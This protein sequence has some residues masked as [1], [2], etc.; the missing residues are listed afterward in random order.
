MITA[1]PSSGGVW[2]NDPLVL[3]H[4]TLALHVPSIETGVDLRRARDRLDFGRGFYVTTSEE[5]ARTWTADVTGDAGGGA[6]AV[7]RFEITREVLTG[8]RCLWFVR[9]TPDADA[10][11]RFVQYCRTGGF[12]HRAETSGGWYDVVAGPVSLNWR[13]RRTLANSDQVS[14]HTARGVAALMQGYLGSEVWQP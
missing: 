9:A 5:Q 6:A 1:T 10:F 7:L 2:Q 8:L 11:W 4:G 13:R 12:A 3:F 14:F